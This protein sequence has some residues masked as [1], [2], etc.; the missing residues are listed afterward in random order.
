ME[1][2]DEVN[3]R[4]VKAVL[5]RLYCKYPKRYIAEASGLKLSTVQKYINE[6]KLNCNGKSVT[7]PKNNT[8]KE[9]VYE[10]VKREVEKIKRELN[11][12]G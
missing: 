5:K 8:L 1:R 10:I 7:R 2:M 6:L 3:P 4:I 12:E 9:L 11:L